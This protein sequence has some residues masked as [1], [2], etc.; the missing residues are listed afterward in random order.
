MKMTL[1]FPSYSCRIHGQQN[2]V[3]L[4][5]RKNCFMAALIHDENK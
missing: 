3:R 2:K 4:T 5:W 1:F